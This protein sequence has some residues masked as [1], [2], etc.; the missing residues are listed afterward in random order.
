MA[1]F[2]LVNARKSCKTLITSYVHF[3]TINK[4]VKQSITY[5]MLVS[6]VSVH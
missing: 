6:Y 1:K 2:N 5:H 3:M 4:I